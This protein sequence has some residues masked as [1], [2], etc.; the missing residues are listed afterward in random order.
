[1]YWFDDICFSPRRIVGYF[2]H[3]R[4]LCFQAKPF[5]IF[6]VAKTCFFVLWVLKEWN[7][8]SSFRLERQ[9]K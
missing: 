5:F 4:G 6:T 7:D 8:N 1:V 9:E 3:I 2:K